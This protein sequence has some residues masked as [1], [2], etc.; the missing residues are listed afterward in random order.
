[1]VRK[2]ET[3]IKGLWLEGPIAH[4]PRPFRFA[5]A[6]KRYGWIDRLER[7]RTEQEG[8]HS[9]VET[10]QLNAIFV[11]IP[12]AAGIS[13]AHSLFGNNVASHTPVF[14]YLALYG[15]RKFDNMYKFSFVRN[16]WDRV[17]SAYNFLDSGGLTDTDR[18]WSEAHLQDYEDV[19]D[20]VCR[21]LRR[22]EVFRWQHFRPQM[23]FLRDPR[24]GE[25]GVNF[26]GRFESLAEDFQMVSG[27][28]G[29]ST[30]LKHI[31]YSP[32]ASS[33]LSSEAVQIISEV[34]QE[35]IYKLQYK[36]PC[37]AR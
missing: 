37:A 2:L 14:M 10:E 3:L 26:L 22:A 15:A 16:P 24:S 6:R 11:H 21:G 17:V 12:K 31:N 23:Y 7:L 18:A 30:S 28:L 34:Y 36:P 8:V 5:I 1:M 9:L 13:V 35:D 32:K 29:V 33:P 19:N 25:I 20:F 4:L 27:R